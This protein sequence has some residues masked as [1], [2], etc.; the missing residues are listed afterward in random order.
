MNTITNEECRNLHT[1]LNSNLIFDHKIC[2]HSPVGQGTCNGDSGSP[3][4]FNGQVH[5]I[6]S[7]GVACA[8]GFPDVYDRVFV[9]R[10]WI[11]QNTN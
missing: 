4:T 1:G 6:V 10:T 5:G 11:T 2:T 8:R 3:L 9:H 7:W